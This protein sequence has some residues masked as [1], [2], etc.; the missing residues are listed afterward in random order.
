MD[1]RPRRKGPSNEAWA[2]I[3]AISAAVI[4]GVVTLLVHVIPG[5][6][7]SSTPGSAAST[8][9]APTA[10]SSGTAA[11]TIDAIAGKWAGRA[12]D[13]SGG[14]FQITL[15]VTQ[16]CMVGKVCGSISVS[17]VPC[18]GQIFLV[19][20]EA[21]EV[22]FRVANFDKKSDQTNCHPGAGERFRLRSDGRLAYR[23]TYDPVAQ[24]TLER[25]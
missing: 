11:S 8:T 23:T 25:T 15:E 16:S 6:H 12:Q 5:A 24:G 21:G 7:E 17:H 13:N 18:Y 4:T 2:A 22:E 9:T 1:E 20:V 10:P 3:G 19:G 14:E